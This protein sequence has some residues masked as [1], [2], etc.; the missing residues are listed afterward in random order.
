MLSCDENV[1]IVAPKSSKPHLHFALW[2]MGYTLTLGIAMLFGY[3]VGGSIAELNAG[4]GH[5]SSRS[6]VQNKLARPMAPVAGQGSP[7][8][9]RRDAFA[10]TTAAGVLLGTGPA[11]AIQG[12]TAGRLP[13]FGPIDE[14]GYRRYS[15]PEG[16]SGGHGV[17]WSEIP[18]YSFDLPASF[19]EVAV[20]I[21]DLGGTELD[22]RFKSADYGDV[23]IIVAPIMRFKDIPFNA[24]VTIDQL[25]TPEQLVRAFA[26]E[27]R[28]EPLEEEDLK[29]VEVEN[30]DG[31]LYYQYELRPRTVV[32]M[33]STGNR[34]F[35]LVAR[36]PGPRQW[37]KFAADLTTIATSFRVS[38]V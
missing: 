37:A 31:L 22:A 10:L 30:R 13:G 28:G 25:G 29:S 15:R 3:S 35:I 16:K 5:F 8:I 24:K 18:P 2:T 12:M 32:S 7:V 4:P 14:R 36:S 21:A 23:A 9:S 26:P 19:E 17:G 1:V 38:Q 27:I 34:L 6:Q 11:G 20:S 33:T